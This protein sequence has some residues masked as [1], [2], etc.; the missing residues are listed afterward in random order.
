MYSYMSHCCSPFIGLE[1]QTTPTTPTD[2][3][4]LA[5]RDTL[6]VIPSKIL[7]SS[8]R[9]QGTTEMLVQNYEFKAYRESSRSSNEHENTWFRENVRDPLYRLASH[10]G[11][12]HARACM[13]FKTIED[14]I[15]QAI[16]SKRKRTGPSGRNTPSQNFYAYGSRLLYLLRHPMRAVHNAMRFFSI[17]AV[18]TA[19][20]LLHMALLAVYYLIITASRCATPDLL[21]V[22]LAYSYAATWRQRHLSRTRRHS[23]ICDRKCR[24]I[25]RAIRLTSSR[26]YKRNRRMDTALA[27]TKQS[28]SGPAYSAIRNVK[29]KRGRPAVKVGAASWIIDSGC[30]SHITPFVTDVIR[31]TITRSSTV[32]GVGGHK[33]ISILAEPT[34]Q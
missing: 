29:S 12:L 17:L 21:P 24:A 28:K 32:T 4:K 20:A 3:V 27:A 10:S 31:W 25:Y 26:K 16:C 22:L 19:H 6:S 5:G 13:T 33:V 30:T 18:R 7:E 2:D 14:G 23:K 34:W 11:E 9:S 15:I 1:I 8:R